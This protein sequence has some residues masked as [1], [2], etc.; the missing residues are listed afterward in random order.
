MW[1]TGG[2]RNQYGQAKLAESA[3]LSC[4]N[5]QQKFID[6]SWYDFATSMCR[7]YCNPFMQPQTGAHALTSQLFISTASWREIS[8]VL[9][10]AEV[11][12]AV[13]DL[14]LQCWLM[15]PTKASQTLVQ[16]GISWQQAMEGR[17]IYSSLAASKADRME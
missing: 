12:P 14:S 6:I 10:A 7:S 15:K 5:A 1:N 17:K 3:M 11:A 8:A 2:I 16:I 13:H 4:W 9:T